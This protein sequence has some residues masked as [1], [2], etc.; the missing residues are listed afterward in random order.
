MMDSFEG[1]FASDE[2]ASEYM[3]QLDEERYDVDRFMENLL[4]DEDP[5]DAFGFD[6]DT[7]NE[8]VELEDDV[9]HLS[10]STGK[11][12]HYY[13]EGN[14]KL[15]VYKMGESMNHP[16]KNMTEQG[17]RLQLSPH[18]GTITNLSFESDRMSLRK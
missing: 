13:D 9:S 2:S 7:L 1:S 16:R 8:V 10:H 6:F 14:L 4:C 12:I 5:E 17:L 15:T 11:P 3:Q 18:L